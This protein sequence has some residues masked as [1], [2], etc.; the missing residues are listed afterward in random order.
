MAY[1][2]I[3]RDAQLQLPHTLACFK[4]GT[5]PLLFIPLA[6][7]S[8]IRALKCLCPYRVSQFTLKCPYAN[9]F[10]THSG[11]PVLYSPKYHS[12]GWRSTLSYS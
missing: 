1:P 8:P 12:P 3:K 7:T 11:P 4:Y 6:E 10:I 5:V 9:L 2:T